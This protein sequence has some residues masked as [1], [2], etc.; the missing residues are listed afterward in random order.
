MQAEKAA[1]NATIWFFVSDEAKRPIAEKAPARKRAPRYPQKIEPASG[2]PR[3]TEVI[4]VGKR[5]NE[6]ARGKNKHREKFSDNRVNAG[7]RQSHQR[8]E[9]SAP[10]FLR[11]NAHRERG[12]EK[13]EEDRQDAEEV[14]EL[15]AVYQ[16]VRREKKYAGKHEKQSG[17]DIGDRT[18]IERSELPFHYDKRD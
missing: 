10:L 5:R 8:L 16:K 6:H 13:G 17:D 9:A 11:E 7:N 4:A 18:H 12:N 15:R 1:K 3:A 14:S 2:E